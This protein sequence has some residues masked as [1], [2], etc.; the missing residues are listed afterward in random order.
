[1]FQGRDVS[2][3]Y[4]TSNAPRGATNMTVTSVARLMSSHLH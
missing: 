2:D 3:F 1:L 4:P